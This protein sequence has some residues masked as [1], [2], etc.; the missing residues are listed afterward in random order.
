MKRYGMDGEI[1]TVEI[2]LAE[3]MNCEDLKKLVALVGEKPPTRKAELVAAVARHL[4]GPR[5]R[6]LWESLDELQRAAVA[7]VVHSNSARFFVD[8]FRAKYGR[9]PNWATVDKRGYRRNPSALRFFFY[10]QGI[11]PDDLKARLNAVVPPPA[12]AR[13]ETLADL[14]A[15][16][17]LPFSHWNR[18]TGAEEEGVE[19]VPVA[20]HETERRAQRELLSVLRLI[21]AGKISVSEKTRRPSSS[22]VRTLAGVLEGGDYYPPLPTT[23]QWRD[24]NAGPIRAFAWPVL[25]QAGGLARPSGSK[26]HLTKAGRKVLAEPAA[27]TIAML[28]S[29]WI[30]TTLLDELSRIDCVKGQTG[31]GRRGLTAVSGRRYAIADG[32]A[33]CP[34]GRW[35]HADELFRSMRVTGNNLSVTRNAWDLYLAEPHYGSLGYDGTGYILE[36]RYVYC[37]LLEYA[38]TLGLIDVALIPPAGA[39]NDYRDLWGTD[40]L[41]YF[42]RYDGLMYFRITALGGYCLGAEST[43]ETD[44]MEVRPVLRVLPNLE[45]AAVGEDLEHSD[46]LALDAYATKVSDRV[47][48]LDT[49]KL[50]AAIEAGRSADEIHEFLTARGAAEIPETVSQLLDDITSRSAK[51]RDR[52]L[53]RLVECADPAL[54]TLIANDS[55][56]RKHCMM[57]GERHLVVPA[58][59][60]A[61]FKRTL[62]EIGYLL[63]DGA[64]AKSRRA[65]VSRPAED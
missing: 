4:D 49:G 42:S 53:V 17:Q 44:A 32:L 63:A 57:T 31:K 7:E 60:E 25:V 41:A 47:W 38:A 22:T 18:E 5:L 37:F 34:V 21:D 65:T 54:A 11:M 2:A 58:S 36:E 59:S 51:V 40:D 13:I 27:E 10:G 64:A 52:G 45:V 26:L 48:R 29:E 62:R 35:M 39:R 50:L 30:D 23:D 56:T 15:V 16:Y 1:P 24:D 8:R 46:R 55:R 43:Y 33:E 9:D 28:W 6:A 19:E 12:E 61:A 3:F 14:P 20:V